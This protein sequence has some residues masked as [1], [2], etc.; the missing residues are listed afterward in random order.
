[1]Q[2]LSVPDR[3]ERQ[4]I[5]PTAPEAVVLTLREREI[6]WLLSRDVEPKAIATRLIISYC[7]V[8]SHV[9]NIREKLNVATMT[10]A[11][12]MALRNHWI[13]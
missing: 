12:A 10:A 4:P 7:T 9:A 6:L 5:D 3:E 2:A 8:R 1:M 11:V 13:D